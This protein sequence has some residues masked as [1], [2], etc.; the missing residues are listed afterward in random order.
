MGNKYVLLIIL[1]LCTTG[2]FAQNSKLWKEIQNNPAYI[3]GIGE[4][5]KLENASK[6]AL[7]MLVSTISTN[8]ASK[9][10]YV[11]SQK[12]V[13]GE[14]ELTTDVN[15]IVNTYSNLQIRGAKTLRLT[16]E[17]D[18]IQ[19]VVRYILKSEVD[20]MFRQRGEKAKQ[21]Y[22]SANSAKRR[23]NIGSAIQNY[24]WSL[25]MANSVPDT[26]TL[27]IQDDEGNTKPLVTL[28]PEL[29]RDA[30][31]KINVKI[32][33]VETDKEEGEKILT[34]EVEYHG[35]PAGDL[36]FTCTD[37]EFISDIITIKDGKGTIVL[38]DYVKEKKLEL[39]IDYR[40]L[41]EARRDFELTDV[42][43]ALSDMRFKNATIALGRDIRKHQKSTY[44]DVQ[45]AVAETT[46]NAPTTQAAAAMVESMVHYLD[47]NE[48]QKYIPVAQQIEEALR[49]RDFNK[50]QPLCTPDGWDMIQKLLSYGSAR[51]IGYPNIQFLDNGGDI[52]VRSYPMQF[53]FKS[54]NRRKFTEDVVFHLNTE[55]KITQVAFAL[56]KRAA[57]D[58]LCN[59]G[60]WSDRSKQALV[61]FMETYKTAFALKD[62][63]YI[64][65]IFSD[66][67]L[68][69]TGR[70]VKSSGKKSEIQPTDLSKVEYIKQTKAEYMKNL[71][72]T[73]G[74]NEYVNLKFA[75]TNVKKGGYKNHQTGESMEVYGIQLKQDYY[76]QTYGDTGYLFLAVDL[77]NP[78]QP[79]IHIRTWQPE[80]DVQGSGVFGIAD[81]N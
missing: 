61:N 2:L 60:K 18:K 22:F 50:L 44:A 78:E 24:F 34:V 56:E 38:P 62:L 9:F 74:S 21:Y 72:R 15:T 37:G 25:A 8:V 31:S 76:S 32:I 77:T 51:L 16:T 48:A 64:E 75:D 5:E 12:D 35:K 6:L 30:L 55:G 70:V 7:D 68:I 66:D 1:F 10:D 3:H 71:E 14:I 81:F 67:A 57:D 63:E 23:G 69:I 11:M 28:M 27:T 54:N 4:D 19:R 41:D 73:F 36:A 39:N 52:T 80:A 59:H 65:R 58:I 17:K 29:M 13:N 46:E 49:K 45:V 53:T 42:I 43:K 20:E 47:A 33:D 79:I 26:N 40:G